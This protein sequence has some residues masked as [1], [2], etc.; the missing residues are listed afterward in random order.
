MPT[1]LLAEDDDDLRELTRMVLG[2]HGCEVTAVRDGGEAR[3]RVLHDAPYDVLVLDLDMP[4]CTGLEVARTAREAGYTGPIVLWTGWN[5]SLHDP[6]VAELGLR[7]LG[8][9]DVKDLR[10]AVLEL[11][12][13][14]A[15]EAEAG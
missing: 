11:G 14:P 7:V 9:Q 10:A 2:H 1:L 8:K 12:C 13:A 5:V 15:V 4:V 6:Q 3:E